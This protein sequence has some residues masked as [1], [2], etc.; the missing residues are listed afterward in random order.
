MS[1]SHPTGKDGPPAVAAG[2]P[3]TVGWSTAGALPSYQPQELAAGSNYPVLSPEATID[4]YSPPPS[5]GGAFTDYGQGAGSPLAQQ[6]V[7]PLPPM[8]YPSQDA[9]MQEQKGNLD[10]QDYTQQPLPPQMYGQQ[11][12]Q[13]EAYVQQPPQAQEVVQQQPQSVHATTIPVHVVNSPNVITAA[14]NPTHYLLLGLLLGLFVNLLSLFGLLF[15]QI[16]KNA[17][18][19]QKYLIG[20]GIGIAVNIIGIII[21]RVSTRTVYYY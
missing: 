20:A 5:S 9:D 18:F 4:A 6:P 2:P 7:A 11:L 3:P 10:A 1:S 12:Q 15:P 17:Q 19:R 13:P 8:G 16:Q 21:I 14:G